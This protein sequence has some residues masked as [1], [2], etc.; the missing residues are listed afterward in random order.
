MKNIKQTTSREIIASFVVAISSNFLYEYDHLREEK[1][2]NVL[3]IANTLNFAG[4]TII[5]Y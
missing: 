2:F 5:S 4:S 1:Y 3:L